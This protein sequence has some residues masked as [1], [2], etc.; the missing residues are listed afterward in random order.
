MTFWKHSHV[1][2]CDLRCLF[3]A[4]QYLVGEKCL[5]FSD[6][7]FLASWDWSS[8]EICPMGTTP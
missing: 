5:A 4:F 2:V 3:A 1:S 7:P 8:E 6:I